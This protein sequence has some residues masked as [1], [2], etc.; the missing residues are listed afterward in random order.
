MWNCIVWFQFKEGGCLVAS[1]LFPFS[2]SSICQIAKKPYHNFR[3]M[4]QPRK[5]PP[6]FFGLSSTCRTQIHMHTSY[7]FYLIWLILIL[8][9]LLSC[10]KPELID[11][12]QRTKQD[13]V[14]RETIFTVDT[15]PRD[16]VIIIIT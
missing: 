1:L 5:F 14:P 3:T 7:K 10:E 11:S 12:T 15:I 9:I 4:H 16:T 2:F 6:A 13:S 8:A